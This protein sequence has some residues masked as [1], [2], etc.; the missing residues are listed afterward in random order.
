MVL[1]KA[2][3][4]MLKNKH[5]AHQTEDARADPRAAQ[6]SIESKKQGCVKALTIIVKR[7][8]SRPSAAS[9]ATGSKGRSHAS[10][11]AKAIYMVR[12]QQA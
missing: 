8:R 1:Q 12:R 9:T 3:A 2:R 10:S 5:S 6:Q 11:V 4:R 7:P